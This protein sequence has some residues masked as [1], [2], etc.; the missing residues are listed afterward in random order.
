MQ[1]LSKISS[2]STNQ[3]TII[4]IGFLF[5]IGSHLFDYYPWIFIIL[6]IFIIDFKHIQKWETTL[7]LGFIISVATTWYFLDNN[8]L[9]NS[10]LLGQF[11]LIFVMYMVGLSVPINQTNTTIPIGKA[12]FY[13]LFIF[14]IGYMFSILY[15]YIFIEQN[16]PLTPL[17]MH[18]CFQNEYKQAHVNGGLL[19]S[20][21]LTYYLT[22]MVILL[23]FIL[24]YFKTFKQNGFTYLELIFLLGLSLF[25][26]FLAAQMGRR[27]AIVLLIVIL[28]YL[29]LYKLIKHWKQ[30]NLKVIFLIIILSITLMGVGS[31]F[32]EDT[33]AIQRLISRGFH[34]RRFG[35]WIKGIQVMLDYPFGGG[36]DI[37][38]SNFSK[39]AHNTWID[40]GKDL[41]II[42]FIFF[43]LL[44]LVFIYHVLCISFNKT[45]N[46]FIKHTIVIISITLFTI[47]M[48]EPVFNSDKTFFSY[49]M[50]FL[51]VVITVN[52]KYKTVENV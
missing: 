43:L 30:L 39:L 8:I 31:Y 7:L 29:F 36:Y 5:L 44:S 25:S 9:F 11:T 20:T 32:L 37:I 41:G 47:L 14:F 10:R 51:G 50:F 35:L 13:F 40:I 3:Y 34:D 6:A 45:I 27:T 19:V 26:I 38:L 48:I 2:F 1:L 46:I 23:P 24:L 21:I 18:T 17:G 15:S 33:S 12:F 49:T 4:L 52:N 28:C 42:P 22:F 16:N